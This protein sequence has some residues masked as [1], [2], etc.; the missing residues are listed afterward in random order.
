MNFYDFKAGDI[1]G[2]EVSLRDYAGKVILVI[3]SATECG[4]TPQYDSL[5]DLFEKYG[6][7]GF[8][9]LDFPCNQFGHQAPGTNE[10]IASFCDSRYG[11]TFPI[12]SKIEV[13]GSKEHPL[14]AYLKSQK[15]FGG[16]NP[17]H[18]LTPMLESILERM[19][20]DYAENSDIKWNFTKFLIDREGNVVE[21]FEPT[22]D[23]AAVEEKIVSLLETKSPMEY[24]Y[25]TQNT[26]SSEIK[27]NIDGNVVTNISF[28]G[29]C[30]G[31]LKAIPLLV[32]GWT[33][34]EIEEKLSGVLCGRRPTS[35][36]DQLAR[37]C[38]EAYEAQKE[39]IQA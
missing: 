22:A 11:I 28:T 5:Q 6:G 31:N 32:D 35:C 2:D 24:V 25:K 23:M 33:V 1:N 7:E 36:A 37:A 18:P 9:I 3:N 12:F 14:Y 19:D 20:P 13:N 29:G 21:R 26:C 34:E 30:N 16:L 39:R 38:R 17:G 4:F 27:L 8:V 15:G 10:E